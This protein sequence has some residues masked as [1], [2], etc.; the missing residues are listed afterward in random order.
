VNSKSRLE[1]L[2]FSPF[3]RVVIGFL[4]Q[5]NTPQLQF[6]LKEMDECGVFFRCVWGSPGQKIPKFHKQI[7]DKKQLQLFFPFFFR[8]F[9]A[10]LFLLF[11]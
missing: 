6:V 9:S 7:N 8:V 2:T 5:F 3:Y 4:K 11:L 1:Q 10:F